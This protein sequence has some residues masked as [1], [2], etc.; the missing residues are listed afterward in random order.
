MARLEHINISDIAGRSHP[1]ERFADGGI[2]HEVLRVEG[3]SYCPRSRCSVTL[4]VVPGEIIDH[5]EHAAQAIERYA[6]GPGLFARRRPSVES[7]EEVCILGNPHAHVFFH[8]LGELLKVVAIERAGFTGKY[9]LGADMPAFCT[10]FLDLLGVG[11]GRILRPAAETR[12]AAAWLCGHLNLFTVGDHPAALHALR[13]ALAAAV[14][15]EPGRGERLWIDRRGVSRSVVN[16]E[17]IAPTL[18][19][20]GFTVID[21][22]TLSPRQQV[23]AAINASVI[24]GPHGSGLAHAA[25]MRERGLLLE[26]FSPSHLYPCLTE[27]CGVLGQDYRMLAGANAPWAQYAHGT[28]VHVDPVQLRLALSRL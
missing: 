18:A 26:A 25:L 6:R 27:V 23:A 14:G 22:A 1:V 13:G 9:V 3:L 17:E 12:F 24:A 28:G 2:G 10:G 4:G 11:E 8:W 21:M 19:Q 20:A 16:D 5:G 7:A 15:D